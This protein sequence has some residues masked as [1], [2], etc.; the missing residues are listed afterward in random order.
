METAQQDTWV[1]LKVPKMCQVTVTFLID[2]IYILLN[3]CF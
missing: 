3:K 1:Q 2:F